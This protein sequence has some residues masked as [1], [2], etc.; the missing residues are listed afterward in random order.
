MTLRALV[1][2]AGD[3][4]RMKSSLPKVLHA[5]AGRSLLGHVLAAVA[6]LTR[7]V[8]VVVGRGAA[9]VEEQCG[10]PGIRFFSQR[11]RRGSGH[12]ARTAGRWLEGAGDVLVLCGDAPLLRTSTLR[13]LVRFHR[14]GRHAVTVLTA[15]VPDPRGYG[16][17]LRGDDGRLQAIVEERDASPEERRVTEINSGTYVFRARDLLRALGRLKPDNAKGEYYLTDAV[18]LLARAGRSLGAF[19]AADHQEALGVNTRADLAR[20]EA[21][22]RRRAVD[23]LMEQGVTVMDPGSA[24]VDPGVRVGRDTVLWPQT[25]LLGRTV[26]GPACRLGPWTV[27]ENSRLSAGVSAR[28]SF[29]TESRLGRGVSVGPFAHLRPGSVI[30]AG[31]HLGSFV[32][33]KKTRFGRDSKLNHLA[34]LGDAVVGAGVN[35]GAG[36]ITCN[37]DGFRKRTT[38][39]GR[40]AFIGSNV[41]LVAPVTVGA[42]AVVGAGSTITRDVPAG[43]L[44]LERSPQVVRPGWARRR[45]GK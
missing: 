19:P 35:V 15:R 12:A 5:A 29:I 23:A 16:R 42:G 45:T 13:D 39:I 26:V 22:L 44:G 38:R 11:E 33:T 8:G 21:V 25:F 30:A 2:A 20:A 3:G 37:Y 31:A 7:R 14:R 18:A 4:T 17:I 27:V 1:L 43:A 41:N 40:G 10:A 6:P 36:A 32:E 24:Y 34:Y 28:A 9:E